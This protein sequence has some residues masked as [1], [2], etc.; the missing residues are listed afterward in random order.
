VL[1][2]SLTFLLSLVLLIS[3]QTFGDDTKSAGGNPDLAA[4]DQLYNSG[5]FA[6][7]ADKYQAILK[8]DPKLVAAQVGVI[9]CLLREQKIDDAFM[10]ASSA[11]A[12]QPNSP[13]LMAVMGAVHFRRGEMTDAETSYMK[14]VKTDPQLVAAY[15]GLA[16]VYRAYSLYRH[17][18]DE[19]QAAYKIAP[20]D[21]EVQRAWFRQGSQQ[22]QIAAIEAYL[23]APRGDTPE[24]IAN[25][26]QHLAY[27]KALADKPAHACRLVNKVEQTEAKL[28]PM[29]H[30]PT[31]AFGEGLVVKLN[32]HNAR[33]L[34]DTGAGGITVGHKAAE[35]AGLTR[36]SNMSFR[37]V[38]DKGPQS[39]Y[40]AVA[41]HIRVGE[42][43]FSDCV[44]VV[45]DRNSVADEDGLMGA[46]VF[47]SYLIDIDMPNLKLRLSQLPKRPD[48]TAVPTG[49]STTTEEAS[50]DSEGKAEAAEEE[51]SASGDKTNSSATPPPR[52]PHD[53]YVA[54]E[55]AKWTPVFRFGH[56]L[57]IPTHVNDSP[58][59]LFLIDT[60]ATAN[61]ISRQAA[62]HVTKVSTDPYSHVKGVNGSVSNVYRADKATLTFAH[63]R[64]KNL[65]M[66]AF[67]LS[68]LS[69][70]FGT[71]VSGTLG[72]NL[73]SM[74]QVKIDY[75]DGLVD[76]VYNANRFGTGYP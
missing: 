5:K 47:R 48:E 31:H 55:M 23:A 25:L 61:M 18:Y 17:A 32:D 30:D 64:Q 57:L 37:G 49:L 46:D 4:A 39:G 35:K 8:A 12:A 3:L 56:A 13:P 33:L 63:L 73:L 50:G 19:V 54:P 40:L 70:G 38:G 59:M 7:A 51:Q 58:S 74:L 44:V 52:L 24:Q 28:E 9:R 66:I 45:S 71:E 26:Q 27:L 76:F 43:E 16:R 41:D 29:L 6:E 60:G 62:S 53:R 65:D 22:Q 10:T 2:R 34:L 20:N 72:F 15:L 69:R 42:L 68:N 11:L 75:R 36:I 21:P 67:D 1:G 14:A